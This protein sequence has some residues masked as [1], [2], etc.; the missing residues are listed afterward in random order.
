MTYEC[1][2]G[3]EFSDGLTQKVITCDGEKWTP[4]TL[5]NC[6]R[7]HYLYIVVFLLVGAGVVIADILSIVI[8]FVIVAST[9][10]LCSF[11]VLM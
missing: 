4:Q 9:Y 1:Y 5:P 11:L 10:T 7:K 8:R 6:E 2:Y 3:Y